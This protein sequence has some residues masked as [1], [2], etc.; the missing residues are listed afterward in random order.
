MKSTENEKPAKEATGAGGK[1]EAFTF[2]PS[3]KKQ[4]GEREKNERESLRK[5]KRAAEQA[6]R[7][8]EMERITG[9]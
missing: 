8:K 6:N 3:I 1:T 7:A 9:S 5:S 2:S 4:R